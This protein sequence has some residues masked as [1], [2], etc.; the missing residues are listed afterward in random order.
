M[1]RFLLKGLLRDR[2]RSR[3]PVIVVFIGVVLS[4]CLFAWIKGVEADMVQ[5]SA[6]FGGGH[7]KVT[8][9]AYAQE[10]DQLPNDLALLQASDLLAELRRDHPDMVWTP[11]TRFGGLLDIPDTNG[12]TRVQSPVAGLAVDLLGKSSPEPGILNLKPALVQGRLPS[13]PGEVLLSDD[14]AR[15]LNVGPGDVATLFASDVYG[16]LASA[17]FQIAGTVRFGVNALDRGAVIADITDI[18]SLLDLPDATGEVLGFS[19]DFVY[20][21]AQ[22]SRIAAAFNAEHP[23][24]KAQGSE[25]AKVQKARSA[26]HDFTP[27]M[28]TLRNQAG[29]GQM[30]DLY[31]NTMGLITGIFLIAM[32]IVLWNAGLMGSLRRWGEFGLRLAIGEGQGHVYR[33]LLLEAVM[34]GLVGSIA[35]TL[36]GL[37]IAF[38]FEKVG[39]NVAGLMR[40]SSMMMSGV[41]RARITPPCF[42]IG[43]IPGLFA[44][45]LGAGISGL[46]VYRRDTAKLAKELSE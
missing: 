42:Y 15:R 39:L 44:T 18:Q 3:F 10:A 30:F 24:S 11:R 26:E 14:L 45:I 13:A 31:G 29:L 2:S 1:I 37:G 35:G 33:T 21:D 6:G 5:T 28:V 9:R 4:V 32:S 34:V 7:V 16:S 19:K 25:G 22:A 46:T 40:N 36:V 23:A 20:N 41:M 12:E 17:N 8:T 43:F 38:W 27:Q